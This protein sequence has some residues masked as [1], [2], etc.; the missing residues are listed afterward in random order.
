MLLGLAAGVTAAAA[1]IDLS[2]SA[3]TQNPDPVSRGGAVALHVTVT[4]NDN[5]ASTGGDIH[6]LVELPSNIDFTAS[7]AP[8]GC[9]FNLAASPKTLACTR[10]TALSAG[11]DW[12]V[13]INGKGATNGA[14]ATR[15]TVA[16]LSVDTDGNAANNELVKNVTVQNGAN[17]AV[18]ASGAAGMTGCPAS[19]AAAAGS[20]VS[21]TLDTSNVDGP[22]VATAFRVTAN[23][24]ANTDFSYASATG[25]D[26][27]CSHSSGTVTCN[28]TGAGLASGQHAPLITIS[29]QVIKNSIG[30]ITVGASVDSTDNQTGD[31]APGNNGP[32]Q[33]IVNITP[34]TNLLAIKSMTSDVSG[35]TVFVDGDAVTLTLAARNTGTQS[36]TGVKVIDT[37]PPGFTIGA[38][39]AACSQAGSTITCSV[40]GTLA[41]GATSASFVIP[42][43]VTNTAATGTNV[44]S[45]TRT[46]PTG[47]SNTDASVAYTISPPFAHLILNKSKTPALA[48]AGATLTST[49]TVK[50]SFFSTS[51][52]SGTVTVRD[53]LAIGESFI[54]A[55]SGGNGWTCNA[56]AATPQVVT[57]TYDI[58]GSLA[59][60]TFLPA[61]VILTSSSAPGAALVSNNACTG[62]GISSHTP[63]DT[64]TSC[65]SANSTSTVYNSDLSIAKNVSAAA[66]FATDNDLSYTLTVHNDG[67]D[68]APTVSVQDPLPVWYNNSGNVTTGTATLAGM[69]AGESCT[70]ASTVSCVIKNLASGA[71]RTITIDLHR[72]FTSGAVLTNTATVSTQ[73]AIDGNAGNNSASVNVAVTPVADVQVQSIASAPSP[74]RVGVPLTFT[75]SI[76]N[77]GP[78]TADGVVLRHRLR[79]AGDPLRVTLSGSASIA[80]LPGASCS[81][82]SSF[83]AG[84]YAGDAGIECT[85]ITLSDGEIR[86]LIFSVIP[87]FPFPDALPYSYDTAAKISSTTHDRN[88][89]NDENTNSAT[90][91]PKQIDLTVTDSDTGFESLAF[92]EQIKY[93]VKV[94]NNG[95]SQATVLKLTVTPI[96]PLQNGAALPY[97]MSYNAASS[98]LGGASCA[99]AG[100]DLVCYLAPAPAD[101]TLASSA[102]RT[103]TLAFDTGP[104]TNTPSGTVVFGTSAM[105]ESAE[106][107]ADP[108]SGDTQPANNK[109]SETTTQRP[110]T[111]LFVISKSV[112]AGSPFSL[113]EPFSYTLVVGNLGPSPA[114]RAVVTDLLPQGLALNGGVS[115]SL[116]S[117]TLDT[118]SCSSATVG[119]RVQVTCT[120][121]TLPVAA[122]TGDSANLVTVTIPVRAPRVTY[123]GSFNTDFTNTAQIA[124]DPSVSFDPDSGNN[125]ATSAAHRIVKSSIAGSVY[126]DADRDNAMAGAEK[127][128][129][130][131]SYA[132]YGKDAWDNDVGTAGSPVTISSATGDFLFDRLPTAGVAGYTIVETQPAG[133]YDRFETA[134]SAGGNTPAA[135]CDGAANCSPG[136]A[137]NTIGAIA[138]AKNTAATGYL[139]Q[140]YQGATISGHVYSDVNND[141]LRDSATEAGVAG[142][143]VL[144]SGTTFTGADVCT[145]LGAACTATTNASGQ[146]SFTV[147]P[148]QA[149][150]DYTVTEQGLPSGYFDGKDNNGGGAGTVIAAS[151]GRSGAEAMNLGQ[152]NAG[153]VLS[154]RN[155]GELKASSISGSVFID[156]NSDAVRQGGE[157]GGVPNVAITIA[158]N[159][160]L[161]NAVCPTADVPSCQIVTDGSGNYSFGKLPP[162]DGAGYTV[163]ETPPAGLTHVGT[164][165]GLLGGTIGGAA[166]T[167]GTGVTGAGVNAT[168][169]IVLA[170]D[171]AATGY[172]FAESGQSLNGF[173]WAD[174]NNNGI[175]EAGE[176]G[177][178]GAAVTL[179]GTS[180]NG[181]NVC[182][183]IA[184]NP[185]S[186]VTAADGSY[187]F[188]GIPQSNGT[189]YT[190]SETQPAGY[191]DGKE[192]LGNMANGGSSGA[193]SGPAGIQDQFSGIV[194]PVSGVGTGYNFGEKGASI[195]GKVYLDVDESGSNNSG[196]T[197]L[198]GVTVTLSGAASATTTTAADG[199]Y[200]FGGLP[201]GSYTVTET[202][203]AIYADGVNTA[204]TAG[205]NTGVANVISAIAITTAST[206]TGYLFGETAATLSGTV[207]VD[208]NNNGVRDGGETGIGGVTLSLSGT[209]AD[210]TTTVTRSTATAAG[211]SYSFNGLPTADGAGY[212]VTETQ[213]SAYLDGRQRKGQID[214]ASSCADPACDIAAA[215]IISKIPVDAAK[216]YTLFD[217]GEVQSAGISGKVY[218]DA[219][220]NSSMD[221]GE[222]LAGVTLTLSGT[223]DLG[224]PVSLTTTTSAD[225]SYSFSGLRPSDGSGYTV[226][227]TQPANIG[228]YPAATGTFVGT[229]GG[230]AATDATSG[231]VIASSASGTGYDFREDASSIAGSVYYDD[232]DNGVRDAG[233]V[234]IAGVTL[235][236]T[237]GAAFSRTAQTAADGSYYFLGLPAAT[238]TLTETQ[239]AAEDG[240]ES[241]GTAGG[242]VDNSSFGPQP[243]QNR[244]SGIALPP[245]TGATGYLFG[246]R[247][248]GKGA[249]SGRVYIDANDNQRYDAGEEL[250]GVTLRLSGRTVAGI[251]VNLSTETAADG[252]YQFAG[253]ARSSSTGYAVEEV[254]PATVGDYPAATGT[255]PGSIGGSAVG[256]AALNRITGIVLPADGVGVNYNFRERGSSLAGA[257][258][259]DQNDDGKRDLGESGISGVTLKVSGK[260]ITR[261][262]TSAADG[263]FKFTALPAGSYTLVE[264]QPSGYGDGRESVGSAGGTADNSSFGNSAAQ[265]TISAITLPVTVDASG[266]LFGERNVAG[267]SIAG[268]VYLDANL[269]GVL[270]QNES[271][272]AGVAMKLTGS[273]A[274]GSAVA[275]DTRT[276]ADGSFLFENVPVSAA[277]GYTLVEFQPAAVNDGV[278]ASNGN[279]KPAAAKP[280]DSGN[281]DAISGVLLKADEKLSGYLFGETPVPFLK[282]PIVNGYVWLDRD[283]NR[284]RPLDGSQ[285]G[286]AGWTNELWQGEKLICTVTTNSKGFYQFDN[287]HCPGYEQSGLPTGSGFSIVFRKDGTNLP[288]VPISTGNKG[289]VPSTG[290]RIN[291]ITL[292]MGD[293]VVE[294]NLPLDPAGVVYDSVT[295]KPVPG[296]NVTLTGPAG[297]DPSFQLVGGLKAQSQTVGEDGMYQFLLQNGFPTGVYTLTLKAPPS[298]YLPA[299]SIS[300]PACRG[301]LNVG[302]VPD[303]ALIQAQDGAPPLSATPQL[304]PDR[305]IGLVQGGTHTTQ[306]YFSFFITNGGSAPIL[307]NHMPLDPIQGNALAVTKTTPMVNVTRGDLVPYTV[308]VANNQRFGTGPVL[309]RDEMPPGFKYRSGS[310]TRD[311][312]PAEPQVDGRMLTWNEP[313]GFAAGQKRSYKMMLAVGSGVGDGEYTNR[314]WVDS[315]GGGQMSNVATASVRLTPDATFDCTDIIGKVF[316]DRNVDGYQDQ[317]EPGIPGVR[318]ATARGLLVT[319]DKEGRF[320]VAC[321]QVPNADRGSNF[322]MKLDDRTLP[323][324]YRVTT[325]N[326]RDVRLTR[327]KVT[328]LNFGATVHRVVRVE[329]SDAAFDAGSE[330][331]QPD[332]Q[333][334]VGK[335]LAQ[336]RERPSVVRMAYLQGK[337]E[338][339][340]VQRRLALLEQELRRRWAA[341][342]GQY[343]LAI[344]IEG[345]K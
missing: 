89:G 213:P 336:L 285:I 301:T 59:R 98:V 325:E 324:G 135:V 335:V 171:Q 261:T 29:G 313:A 150:S 333:Q 115:A 198:A 309:V 8:S 254:Q 196:D 40:P 170:A 129:A 131:V 260:G 215:N 238:Y 143:Q 258:Y 88:A 153:N 312:V 281:I 6:L 55:G 239:P 126:N 13:V 310:A 264:T 57:C 293:E 273:A 328:K 22:D 231:I 219:N 183:A 144:I 343:P 291:N 262:A 278:T 82:V 216:T 123:N 205:G 192:Q 14:V 259:V 338:A 152:V 111:D 53:T 36:A 341:M 321:P 158:G 96:L 280:V 332:W 299:P 237:D 58:S 220:N 243:A 177:I 218:A 35:L 178:A 44:A 187:S 142:V 168:S 116:G 43:T 227:E 81:Y 175:K 132:L 248:A 67:P 104:G 202:Q 101:S 327:G 97:T 90:I 201:A 21:F 42:L 76:R 25:T 203:P 257:V 11:S 118:N 290:G 33:V 345:A 275:L 242:I 295:R 63:A 140:E 139:F 296:A 195:A 75:T 72:P 267:G 185:C 20:N 330:Q 148:S 133:Y 250:D 180:V 162:S 207:Y 288:A 279:G 287:L 62:L 77:N 265:N 17:L 49:I 186:T 12:D 60:D 41:P 230:T 109:I 66:L 316:D 157:V 241:A 1:P 253:L 120:L 134:G 160:H 271:G 329:L 190:L 26:W 277:A 70:F 283:H 4:N 102:S 155:F 73:D 128:T 119:G 91:T 80:G 229:L 34:G 48:A 272:I 106:T 9:A 284:V 173:V 112:S 247:A 165:A 103:L 127:I 200:S 300:L 151:A 311:G 212:T 5:T 286:L 15:A 252:T 27:S 71:T 307:N 276:G 87:V 326:P 208:T 236:L 145:V 234:G 146:Y 197:S 249:I 45:V 93:Q 83:G 274:D 223:D 188:I 169:A 314:A 47:G 315:S 317:G 174:V 308:T 344:E 294:Q 270:D 50:N 92:G 7:V 164:Q 137:H 256:A 306:Y 163:T 206:N 64:S 181:V 124:V 154:E 221:A 217:F 149:G 23:L 130:S 84:A 54:P 24:P 191:D 18:L 99:M 232:N 245:A 10:S 334:R 318:L 339:G 159:D 110:K 303:P 100:A 211:G 125:S 30:T 172:N 298:G 85:N 210:G 69:G 32:S 61:L 255:Q 37:V 176:P 2:V 167:S 108:F 193:I 337:D 194:L 266:Y 342:Q 3:Y 268:R 136:A 199:S 251:D 224:V 179:S 74:V 297:F 147:P 282:P 19:C 16:F 78:S 56:D 240:R 138:L 79:V 113:N 39:P 222:A 340:L 331:L 214:G 292:S 122:N 68:T 323:S 156:L 31:P 246:E 95:P 51:A 209:A 289:S 263:S 228:N 107:G 65:A 161:G 52:A 86:Q 117:G 38:L 114:L 235:T 141:G 233:E 269:N 302:L 28:Y 166:R 182:S 121:G 305:C 189:G 46:A 244:I 225:G 105:V 304:D 322:V 226:T 94:Q 184:P 320:H 204:G 319:T